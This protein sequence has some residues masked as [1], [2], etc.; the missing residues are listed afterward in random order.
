MGAE[1][2]VLCGFLGRRVGGTAHFRPPRA[3]SSLGKENGRGERQSYK[4]P[5]ELGGNALSSIRFHC[6]L[7]TG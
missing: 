2:G 5:A 3:W 1:S 6:L 7:S 4:S